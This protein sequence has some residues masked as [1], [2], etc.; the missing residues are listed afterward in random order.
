M[1]EPDG[2]FGPGPVVAPRGA[3]PAA[4][5]SPDAPLEDGRYHIYEPNPI[6][7]WVVLVWL[8]FIVFALVYLITSLLP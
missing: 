6:P 2:P 7:W 1:A 8:G 3:S 5:S 4:A